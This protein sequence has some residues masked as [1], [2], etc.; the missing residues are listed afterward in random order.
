MQAEKIIQLGSSIEVLAEELNSMKNK[1]DNLK[2]LLKL[3][4][5]EE[6]V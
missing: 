2:Q 4:K 1:K 6:E 5:K 3:K